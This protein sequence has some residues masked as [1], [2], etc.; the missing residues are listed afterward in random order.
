[1]IKIYVALPY[2]I[3]SLITSHLRF[4]RNILNLKKQ[5]ILAVPRLR[6]TGFGRD[7]ASHA[8]LQA[9]QR[10]TLHNA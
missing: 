6:W 9:A 1:M 2:L 5:A 8:A 4:F 10:Q 7:S 3:M